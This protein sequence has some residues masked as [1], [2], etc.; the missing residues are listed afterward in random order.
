MSAVEISG[1]DAVHPGYGFLSENADFARI[2]REYKINFIGP[3]PEHIFALGN[4]VEARALALKAKVPMLPGSRGVVR[5]EEEAE[6]IAKE[7]GYPLIIKAAAGGGGRGMKVV[8]QPSELVRQYQLA[9][10]EALAGFGNADCF[11]RTLLC[12]AAAYRDPVGRR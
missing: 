2:C 6:A 11:Y 1:A 5:T 4:K 8:T 12:Q 7:I 10:A 3:D 9:Q